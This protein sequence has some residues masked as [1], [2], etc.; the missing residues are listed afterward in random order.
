MSADGRA[1]LLF[2]RRM[3]SIKAIYSNGE[4]REIQISSTEALDVLRHST[5]HLMAAAVQ[6]L[7]PDAHLGIGPATEDGF[8]YDFE[9]KDPFS[10]EDLAKIEEEM[11]KIAGQKLDFEPLLWNKPE[12]VDYFRGKGEHLKVELIEEKA[13]DTLSCYRLGGMVDFCRGPHVNNTEILNHFQL[14]SNAASYWR[15]DENREPLQRIY[16]IAF[17]SQEE[18]EAYLHKLEEARKRDHRKLGKELQLFQIFDIAGQGFIYWLPKG[19]VMRYEL[20]SFTRQE[21]LRRGYQFV[22]IPHIARN[23]L[24]KTSGHYDYFR[25]NMY[26]LDIEEE[27]YVIKPMNCPGHILIYKTD[28][29]SYRDLPIR[30]A[31]FGTVY[32]YEKSGTLH[33]TMRVRGFTQDDA[34]IFCTPEQ[35]Y[36]EVLGTIDF[37]QFILKTFGFE[38]YRIELSVW[39]PQKPENYAGTAENWQAAEDALARALQEKGLSYVRKEG[40]AAFYGPKIDMKLIDAIGREWQ[41]TTIQFDFN[42][43]ERFDVCYIGPDSAKHRVIMIHRALFGSIERFSGILIEHFAGAFPVWLSP[44]QVSLIPISERH[45][46]YARQVRDR[47]VASGFR[48]F[49]DDRNE[50]MGFKIRDAQVQKIPYML[51]MGDK[52]AANGMVSVRSRTRGDEG[53]R[54]LENFIQVLDQQVR[55]RVVQS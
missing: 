29:H 52:E 27:E 7:F 9:I 5:S 33:G 28:L 22:T 2:L 8:Y 43:P 4:S 23:T 24:F 47:L 17:F 26:V 37:A 1:F 3:Q 25:E 35:A 19:T 11:R 45:H 41:A 18:L 32:R 12:A 20:E 34:H 46:E 31:E 36:S 48:V 21:H 14:V 16:G 55:D 49:F 53:Q 15:G 50:K 44:V 39:D 51:V 42:L 38:D 40:E 10:Q 54:S 6:R 30:Y 13:G